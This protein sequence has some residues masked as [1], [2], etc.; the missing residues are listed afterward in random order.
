MVLLAKIIFQISDFFESEVETFCL[1][2]PVSIDSVTIVIDMV[3]LIIQCNHIHTVD[4][5]KDTELPKI[6]V[7][8]YYLENN[9]KTIQVGKSISTL[10]V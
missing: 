6:M 5:I 2:A 10:S 8:L 4:I 7:G 9:F 3:Q 1:I